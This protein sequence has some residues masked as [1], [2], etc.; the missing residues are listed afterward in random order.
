MNDLEQAQLWADKLTGAGVDAYT[1]PRSATPPCVLIV[2]PG[3]TFDTD[4]SALN[5]WRVYALAPG[6]GNLDAW[7]QLAAM[8]PTIVDLLPVRSRIYVGV[9]LDPTSPIFP[10]FMY[11]FEGSTDP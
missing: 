4:C 9:S 10:A 7:S 3:Q 11:Q 1:D 5:D 8:Q 6:L 2:P